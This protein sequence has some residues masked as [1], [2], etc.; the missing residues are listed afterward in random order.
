MQI[1][2]PGMVPLGVS[3]VHAQQAHLMQVSNLPL[4]W[5]EC[6]GP[7]LPWVASI[8]RPGLMGL[9]FGGAAAQDKVAETAET[10]AHVVSRTQV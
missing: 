1:A 5:L 6:S 7:V 8:T 3:A 4:R 9:L 2:S 10:I